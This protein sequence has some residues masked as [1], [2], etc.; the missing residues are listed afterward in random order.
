VAVPFGAATLLCTPDANSRLEFRFLK[1]IDEQ[2][3]AGLADYRELRQPVNA[4]NSKRGQ[5][6][7]H[8]LSIFTVRPLSVPGLN[9][10]ECCFVQLTQE[11]IRRGSSTTR[12]L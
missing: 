7:H 5:S 8:S 2:T 4:T 10:V 9:L 1:T 6:A 12:P 11:R 3:P